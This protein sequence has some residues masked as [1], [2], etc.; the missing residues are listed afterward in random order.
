MP[1]PENP[2]VS[3]ETINMIMEKTLL[4]MKKLNE[5]KF[6]A[7]LKGWIWAG[8]GLVIIV[9]FFY[10]I[11]QKLVDGLMS[12]VGVHTNFANVAVNTVAN[13]ATKAVEIANESARIIAGTGS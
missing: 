13:N 6:N 1:L 11:P 2:I 10:G 7:Q 9:S 4:E 5:K 8:V 3:A 12:L